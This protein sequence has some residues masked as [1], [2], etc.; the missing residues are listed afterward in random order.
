MPGFEIKTYRVE[1]LHTG[2]TPE[3]AYQRF[4][5]LDGSERD[6]G[7]RQHAD[8]IFVEDEYV[9]P[10]QAGFITSSGSLFCLLRIRDFRDVYDILRSEKPVFCKH[11]SNSGSQDWIQITTNEEPVGE[12]LVDKSNPLL[13]LPALERIFGFARA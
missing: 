7:T 8:L 12:G 9:R 3:L 11:P 13:I 4:I 2:S 1:T 10:H 5:I 6:Q